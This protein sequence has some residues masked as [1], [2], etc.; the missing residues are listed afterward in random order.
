MCRLRCICPEELWQEESS[1]RIY[2]VQGPPFLF[3]SSWQTLLI[4]H[5]HFL[6]THTWQTFL[7]DHTHL[8]LQIHTWPQNSW[9][10]NGPIKQSKLSLN[11]LICLFARGSGYP[12]FKS[13]IQHYNKENENDWPRRDQHTI[14][15]DI[16]LF[17]ILIC[18]VVYDQ[19]KETRGSKSALIVIPQSCTVCASGP[20]MMSGIDDK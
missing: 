1:G 2:L 11:F 18:M 5:T 6:W 4:E 10:W 14:F 12:Y 19:V 17:V 20:R 7:I 16:L 15:L 8:V 3:L 9:Q 13:M